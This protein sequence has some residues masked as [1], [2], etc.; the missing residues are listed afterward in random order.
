MRFVRRA[1]ARMRHWWTLRGL[2]RQ[3]KAQQRQT[4]K[5]LHRYL[6]PYA[7]TGDGLAPTMQRVPPDDREMVLS[8]IRRVDV[9]TVGPDKDV[10]DRL[11][12]LIDELGKENA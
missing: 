5:E 6:A 11:Y 1:I 8:L 2:D 3:F 10:V 9:G 7:Q 4:R 12:E